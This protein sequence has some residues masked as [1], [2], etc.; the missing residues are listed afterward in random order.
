MT[1]FKK[2]NLPQNLG[3]ICRLQQPASVL[4]LHIRK[5]SLRKTAEIMSFITV[6]PYG[7]FDPA[8][9]PFCDTNINF[10]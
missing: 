6:P 10:T 3:D 1:I 8:T 7:H 5:F 2:I 4:E 9:T